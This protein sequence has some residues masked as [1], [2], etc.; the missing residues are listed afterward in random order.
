MRM[1]DYIPP[2][3]LSRPY[4][5]LMV[6]IYSPSPTT[7][8]GVVSSPVGVIA[9]PV[10]FFHLRDILAKLLIEKSLNTQAEFTK[11]LSTDRAVYQEMLR[12]MR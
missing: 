3:I 2:D 8:K 7:S 10:L 12:K 6:G 4:R 1:A 11:Q 9:V 5:T